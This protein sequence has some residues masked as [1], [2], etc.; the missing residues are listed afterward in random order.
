MPPTV[1]NMV[2]VFFYLAY[3]PPGL[4][5]EGTVPAFVLQMNTL[6]LRP[7]KVFTQGGRGPT[8][9]NKPGS[10]PHPL[11]SG[12]QLLIPVIGLLSPG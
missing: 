7:M 11:A 5:E 2:R 10:S 6:R 12:C 1:L 3:S 8:G 4:Y 9:R